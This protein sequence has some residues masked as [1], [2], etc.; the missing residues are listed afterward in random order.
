MRSSITLSYFY[1][2]LN[3]FSRITECIWLFTLNEINPHA[4]CCSQISRF[5]QTLIQCVSFEALIWR[6]EHGAYRRVPHN[7]YHHYLQ[8]TRMP[9][10]SLWHYQM[11][12]VLHCSPLLSVALFWHQAVFV[13][14][15]YCH[16][17]TA[18]IT[19]LCQHLLIFQAHLKFKIFY[20]TGRTTFY[21]NFKSFSL[22][23]CNLHNNSKF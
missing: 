5:N 13:S 15:A 9:M 11:K 6:N 7:R 8:T 14:S 20:S 2:T 12:M 16:W 19:G 23:P 1:N 4:L 18:R 10:G 17:L 3:F 22:H 21:R